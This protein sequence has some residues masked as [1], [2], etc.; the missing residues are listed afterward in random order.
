MQT[1]FIF[2]SVYIAMIATSF[3]E[4]YAEGRNAWDRGKIGWKIKIGKNFNLTAYHFWLFWVMFPSL[5]F[6][7]MLIYGWDLKLFGV[8]VSVYSS[9]LIIEDFFW[10]VVNPEVKFK[11]FWSSFSDYYPWVKLGNKKIVPVGYI[12]GIIISVS[13]W[14]FLWR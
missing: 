11:E 6:L 12:L 2:I 3:W 14:Y 10:Y 1:F 8:L 5:I 9:G 13:S 7:P 4:S